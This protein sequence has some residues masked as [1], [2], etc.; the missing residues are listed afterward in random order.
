MEKRTGGAS[1]LKERLQLLAGQIDKQD[2]KY[3]V[4]D[5]LLSSQYFN[6]EIGDYFYKSDILDAVTETNFKFF[7]QLVIENAEVKWFWIIEESYH[8]NGLAFCKYCETFKKYYNEGIQAGKTYEKYQNCS[9]VSEMDAGLAALKN[10]KVGEGEDELERIHSEPEQEGILELEGVPTESESN[11]QQLLL[12]VLE[13]INCTNKNLESYNDF[14]GNLQEQNSAMTQSISEMRLDM[15]NLYKEVIQ[16][17]KQSLDIMMKSKLEKHTLKDI[18]LKLEIE[19]KK[20]K[21]L[22]K[23]IEK[24]YSINCRLRNENT[25]KEKKY[26]T[27]KAKYSELEIQN[28]NLLVQKSD[29]DEKRLSSLQKDKKKAVDVSIMSKPD[30]QPNVKKSNVENSRVEKNDEE[31]SYIKEF[32]DYSGDNMIPIV[33]GIDGIREKSNMLARLFSRHHEKAFLKK[34]LSD[35]EGSIFVKMMELKFD[36]DKV[37]LVKRMIH[38]DAKISVVELYKLVSKNPSIEELNLFC[39]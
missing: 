24:L 12:D 11:H 28:Q 27:L 21:Q 20:N 14:I 17:Q 37:S 32:A 18:E 10:D 16:Y 3:K 9:S 25:D 36:K 29:L 35:Q 2:P 31:I 1:P 13:E 5:T 30:E 8:G 6:N 38:G 15:K 34:S 22:L 4:L 23:N 39:S 19:E 7:M 26:S 33:N